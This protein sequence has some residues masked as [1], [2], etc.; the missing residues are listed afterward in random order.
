MPVA[1]S[2]LSEDTGINSSDLRR[3][4]LFSHSMR[5]AIAAARIASATH[6]SAWRVRGTPA[7]SRP[8]GMP[9]MA[10]DAQ[11]S[12]CRFRVAADVVPL[13]AADTS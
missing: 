3:E 13:G 4:I 1:V 7:P 6:R 2:N 11:F 12:A 5:D 9:V 10:R 8:D